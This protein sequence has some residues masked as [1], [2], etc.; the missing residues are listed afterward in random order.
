MWTWHA[1]RK[2]EWGLVSVPD[3]GDEIVFVVPGL[4]YADNTP[5]VIGA[6][7]VWDGK[8]WKVGNLPWKSND[9]IAIDSVDLREKENDPRQAPIHIWFWYLARDTENKLWR[10][11]HYYANS[12]RKKI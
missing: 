8:E 2:G 10:F 7:E 1:S 9:V 3:I 6:G 11:K 12:V 4:Y 5:C